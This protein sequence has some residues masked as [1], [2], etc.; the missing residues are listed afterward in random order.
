MLLQ[1]SK[2]DG[3]FLYSSSWAVKYRLKLKR[4]V[5]TL[6]R[7][8]SSPYIMHADIVREIVV[9]RISLTIYAKKLQR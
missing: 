3:N 6:Y 8:L 5:D 7:F 4:E 2:K 9:S 1:K